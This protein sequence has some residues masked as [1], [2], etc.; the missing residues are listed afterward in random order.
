MAADEIGVELERLASR[1]YR[2]AEHAAALYAG[3]KEG[4]ADRRV[5]ER[6]DAAARAW[7]AAG[8][9]VDGRARSLNKRRGRENK[10]TEG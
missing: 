1:M 3:L 4:G 5:L 8:D 10:T 2:K 6:L 7:H 9:M